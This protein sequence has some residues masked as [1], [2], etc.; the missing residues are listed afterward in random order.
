MNEQEVIVYTSENSLQCEK[1]L[2][3]LNQSDIN[4]SERNVT[5]HRKYLDELQEEGI[6]GTPATFVDKKVVLGTQI[7]KIKHALGISN[8][9]HSHTSFDWS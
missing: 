3:Q 8:H 2:E 4:Y 6:F 9:Y 7:N 1:L 5:K